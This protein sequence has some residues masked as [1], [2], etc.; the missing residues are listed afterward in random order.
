MIKAGMYVKLIPKFYAKNPIVQV[1][2]YVP[3]RVTTAWWHQ[4]YDLFVE[5]Y[6]GHNLMVVGLRYIPSHGG[7]VLTDY[8]EIYNPLPE[9]EVVKN[10]VIG[11]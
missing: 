7:S 11:I 1:I 2:D 6:D 3:Q 4:F 10:N 5:Y 8:F 9:L